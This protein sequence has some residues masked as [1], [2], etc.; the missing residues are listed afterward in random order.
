MFVIFTAAA[1]PQGPSGIRGFHNP[2]RLG[3][4]ATDSAAF[5][6]LMPASGLS[7]SPCGPVPLPVVGLAWAEWFSEPGL[8]A[9]VLFDM[10]PPAW[11]WRSGWR[12]KRSAHR[13]CTITDDS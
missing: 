9:F 12:V 1:C 6:Y 7:P 8:E 5:W 10:E 2:A 3:F 13:A 4:L 11:T